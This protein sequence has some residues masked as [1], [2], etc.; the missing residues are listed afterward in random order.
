MREGVNSQI[1]WANAIFS[2]AD[3]L[4]NAQ[5]AEVLRKAGYRVFLPQEAIV[6]TPI[7][8]SSPAAE[9]IFRVDTSAILDSQLLVACIDQETID[10]G[11]ACEIGVAFAYG[12]PIIGLYT[13][14]RQ[15]RKD[16]GQMYKNL[17]V[18]GAIES[19]G[20][21]VLGKLVAFEGI[22]RA[23]K[24][25][26]IMCMTGLLH[27]CNVPIVI[28]GELRSPIAPSLREM[29]R[30]GSSAFLKTYFFATDRAWAYETECLPALKR[31]ELVLWDRYVDSAI[32]YRTVELLRSA[33]VIDLDFVKEIN[34][35]FPRPDLTIYIDISVE[36]SLKRARVAGVGEPYSR[37]FLEEVRNQYLRLA[38]SKEY[39]IINGEKPLDTVAAEV[40][41]VIRQ[42]LKEL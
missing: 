19:T 12:I 41:H 1:Y 20:E 3:R 5:C 38:S 35:P 6:N 31:G 4:F 27:G 42:H 22:D 14:I 26:V 33:S 23:G 24:S 32:I 2:M 8:E 11:V 10:C 34:R 40:S 18:V 28:C 16:R 39:F 29:L 13:D 36:T 7:D 17:Y 15:Y 37:E 9:D 30:R 21:I 25:S